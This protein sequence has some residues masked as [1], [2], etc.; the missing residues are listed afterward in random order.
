MTALCW[1]RIVCCWFCKLLGSNEWNFSGTISQESQ[2]SILISEYPPWDTGY[3]AKLGLYIVFSL[4]SFGIIWTCCKRDTF[5]H[6]HQAEFMEHDEKPLPIDTRLLGAL[7]EK[8]FPLL[9]FTRYF[10]FHLICSYCIFYQQHCFFSV[11]HLQ[12]LFITKKWSLKLLVL[13]KWVQILWRL[14][15]PLFTLT[16]SYT[17]MRLVFFIWF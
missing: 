9:K 17:S 4:S 15:N 8:V 13:R 10:F 7:A 5:W 11:E 14:L 3:S 6:S 2:D 16:I 12:R 1:K